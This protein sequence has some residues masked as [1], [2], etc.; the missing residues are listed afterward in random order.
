MID[1]KVYSI[2]KN[3]PDLLTSSAEIENSALLKKIRTQKCWMDK[4]VYVVF[5][6]IP[7]LFIVFFYV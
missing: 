6:N 5:N 2:Y 3:M 7:D 1:K 4:K